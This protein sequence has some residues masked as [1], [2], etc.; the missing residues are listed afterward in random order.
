MEKGYKFTDFLISDQ[1]AI[2]L[3]NHPTEK[4]ILLADYGED[5]KL[6]AYIPYIPLLIT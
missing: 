2:E 4:Y 5:K 6:V 3:L 1:K